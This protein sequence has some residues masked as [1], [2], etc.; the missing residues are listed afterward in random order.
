MS[1]RGVEIERKFRL[2]AA[3]APEVLAVHGAVAKRIEQVY[4]RRDRPAATT[5]GPS[6]ATRPAD[7]NDGVGRVRRT[8][9]PDGSVS[10]R[11]NSKRRVGAFAFDE[12]EEAI[13]PSEWTA[14]LERADPDRRPVRKTRHVV[15]H[16]A[17]EL[18]IDVFEDPAGLVVVEV[19]L[20]SEDEAVEL[21]GWLGEWR[22]VTGDHRY[23]NASLARRDA[24]VPPYD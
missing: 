11:S 14:A 2:R 13:G 8:E 21:P 1:P 16:G 6:D 3:P 22:E 24:E 5:S 10:Y 12:H 20:R 7:A 4:L 15:P 19:E 9:L 23:F 17:Q 18:E